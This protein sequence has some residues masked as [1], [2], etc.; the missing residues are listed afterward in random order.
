M[1]LCESLHNFDRDGITVKNSTANSSLAQIAKEITNS[2]ELEKSCRGFVTASQLI[3]QSENCSAASSADRSSSNHPK[4]K[5]FF[6][7]K[8]P[9]QQTSVESFF[10]KNTSDVQRQTKDTL[11]SSETE[12]ED[13]SDS[14]EGIVASK[15]NDL[16]GTPNN[17]D[18]FSSTLCG[19]TTNG[20]S[21]YNI[22]SD[23]P[24]FEHNSEISDGIEP[25]IVSDS[26]HC[27]V[28]TE[29][30]KDL[31]KSVQ[32]EVNEVQVSPGPNSGDKRLDKCPA[33]KKRVSHLDRLATSGKNGTKKSA[34]TLLEL[35]C[36]QK[37]ENT[38]SHCPEQLENFSGERNEDKKEKKRKMD[39][40]FGDSDED[41]NDKLK[42][43]VCKKQ[44][45]HKKANEKVKA[46]LKNNKP[47]A[48]D[49]ELKRMA[50]L[51]VRL[52]MPYY[53]QR[54]ITSRDVFKALART[55]SQH[56]SKCTKSSGKLQHL[57][58]IL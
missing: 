7:K 54:R 14:E 17:V 1:K 22:L 9:L 21:N 28:K 48:S 12:P 55:L 10:L 35:W 52:L 8:D 16:E 3:A 13:N 46:T 39:I 24:Y 20:M 41:Q 6:L 42:K 34:C 36:K 37:P 45:P 19:L 25:Y 57:F 53:K 30:A 27:T 51:V 4:L 38:A 2:M 33:S 56:A 47:S 58:L 18:S 44:L 5:K 11:S 32:C 43:R 15:S 26:G 23:A 40:L 50:E 49:A 29:G 31:G